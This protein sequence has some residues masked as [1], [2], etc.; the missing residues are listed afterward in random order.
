MRVLF[1][2]VVLTSWLCSACPAP[3]QD[4]KTS[5]AS[6][7]NWVDGEAQVDA[8]LSRDVQFP[9]RDSGSGCGDVGLGGYCDS[10][11]TLFWCEN[12]LIKSVR[13]QDLD[14]DCALNRDLGG[15][16][17]LAGVGESCRDWPCHEEL[18]CGHSQ[19]CE[20]AHEDAGGSEQNIADVD[21]LDFSVDAA[22]V[23][24][25]PLADLT[26]TDSL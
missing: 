8:A 12:N 11:G 17:C 13:C 18:R 22:P 24:A 4:T 25:Q 10:T 16:W 3:T 20:G 2:C 5:A 15:Y 19:R 1:H 6:D 21:G 7:A 9:P 14:L 26:S 23:D